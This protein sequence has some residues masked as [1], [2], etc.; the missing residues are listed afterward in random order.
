MYKKY[1]SKLF[2]PKRIIHTVHKKQ[3]LLVLTFPCPLSFEIRSR[4]QKCF[5][6]YIAFCSL[7]VVYHPEVEFPICSTL[8]RLL[9]PS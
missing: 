5:K 7:K 2:V 6:S 8:K 4:L 3:I 9:I 1:L